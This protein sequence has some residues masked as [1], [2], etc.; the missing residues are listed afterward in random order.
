MADRLTVQE[1][2]DALRAQKISPL[3]DTPA[4]RVSVDTRVRALCAS[5]PIQEHWPV[6]DLESAY[7]QALNE[8]PNVQDLVRDG[9]TGTVNLRGYDGTYTMD[10]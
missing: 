10:E 9:Y 7:Q 6:L 2:F 3:I 1:F 4:V 8:L 5:Y